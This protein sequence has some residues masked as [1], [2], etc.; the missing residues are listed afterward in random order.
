MMHSVGICS[1]LFFNRYDGSLFNGLQSITAW[2]EYFN[3]PSPEILG[4]MNSSGF[5]PGIVASFFADRLNDYVGRKRT[6]WVGSVINMIGIVLMSLSTGVGTFCGG[7]VLIGFGISTA[8][9]VGPP[10]LQETAHPRYRAQIGSFCQFTSIYYIAAIMSA[11]ICLRCL[12]VFG[13]IAWRAPCWV[14][15]FGPVATIAL[16]SN[17]PESPRWLVSKGR[18]EEARAVLVKWHANGKDD[19]E[20]VQYEFSQIVDAINEEKN[21]PQTRHTDS[22][23]SPG[24]RHRLMILFVV[25]ISINWVGNGIVAYYLNPI[26]GSIGITSSVLQLQILLYLQIW[27]LIVSTLASLYIDKIGRRPLWLTATSQMFSMAVVLGLSGRYAQTTNKA[28]GIA[29]VPFFFLFFTAYDIAYTPMSYS[30][31]IEILTY[32]LRTKGSALY[33]TIETA[34]VAVNTWVNPVALNSIGWK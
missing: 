10:L 20:L 26:L 31:P 15:M 7:R 1:A 2:Q 32:S 6:L 16:T 19:D 13:E 24:N 23:R 17:M 3:H 4:L 27:N 5:L 28:F 29:V 30:Y 22:L 11:A 21:P 9:T 12:N 14:Q 25:G 8:L 34:A 18:I 33:I